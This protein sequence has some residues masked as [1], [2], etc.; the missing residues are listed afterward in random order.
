MY[1]SKSFKQGHS[2][3]TTKIPVH[4]LCMFDILYVFNI[5]SQEVLNGEYCSLLV[6]VTAF[7]ST[8]NKILND[9]TIRI[10]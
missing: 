6:I 7:Q 9:K 8:F 10:A 1:S 4:E 3:I 2:G 5:R